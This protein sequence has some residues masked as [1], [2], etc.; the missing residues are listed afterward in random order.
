MSQFNLVPFRFA[1]SLL[2][3]CKTTSLTEISCQVLLHTLMNV[4]DSP[5]TTHWETHSPKQ[6]KIEYMQQQAIFSNQERQQ[7]H[8]KNKTKQ[9]VS[10]RGALCSMCCICICICKPNPLCVS[11]MFLCAQVLCYCYCYNLQLQQQHHLLFVCIPQ[12]SQVP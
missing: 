2:Y 4:L 6:E 3:Q 5:H 1:A 8:S 12:M 11:P 7:L 10:R 9:K